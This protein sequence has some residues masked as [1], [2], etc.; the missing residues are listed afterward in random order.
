MTEQEFAI[1]EA[2]I[3]ALRFIKTRALP[4]DWTR[5]D[6]K[7]MAAESALRY[8]E[9]G[10]YK[11]YCVRQRVRWDLLARRRIAWR[12]RAARPGRVALLLDVADDVD[13]ETLKVEKFARRLDY[14][15]ERAIVEDEFARATRSMSKRDRECARDVL[16]LGL[17]ARESAARRG[18]KFWRADR[19]ARVAKRALRRSYSEVLPGRG[20]ANE[21]GGPAETQGY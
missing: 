15:E 18:V 6:V 10:R 3:V 9:S 16:I 7:Q 13:G 20:V 14:I 21:V 19:A 4:S 8:L 17:S 2:R 11:R 1:E 5:D 12:A